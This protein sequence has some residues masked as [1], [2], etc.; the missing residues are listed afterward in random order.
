MIPTRMKRIGSV[1]GLMV[2]LATGS[3]R[4]GE[5][6]RDATF[7]S[8]DGIAI[9]YRELGAGEPIVLLAGGP[10]YSGDYLV[11]LAG[12]LAGRARAVI[13]DARG[14]GKSLIEPFEPAK[15]SM[16]RM[17]ADLEALRVALAL[18]RW[19]LLGHSFG[20][21]LAM[22]YAVAHPERVRALVLVGSAGVTH[23]FNAWYQPNIVSRL[24]AGRRAELRSWQDPAR[25]MADP[26]AAIL[27]MSR[28]MAPAM[29]FDPSVAEG[30]TD[31]LLKEGIFD[32]RV[33][34]A[35]QPY[36]LSGYDFRPGLQKLIA[37]V[38]VIQGRQDPVGETTAYQIR[39]AI[40][41]AELQFVESCAH[42]PFLE[43][44]DIFMG[45]LAD[46]LDRAWRSASPGQAR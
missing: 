31:D 4:A 36:L 29:T 11:P 42:W 45:V 7:V 39:D 5:E 14:T 43:R 19:T 25:F 34:M 9:Y 12:D 27:A 37:P 1:A 23:E 8:E 6:A 38:L 44:R 33:T 13:P 18:D 15:I 3:P 22:A 16:D 10:G 17:V 26:N 24:D 46:F 30:M 28:I 35:M 2:A 21:G 20:G 40:E 41:G 32:P